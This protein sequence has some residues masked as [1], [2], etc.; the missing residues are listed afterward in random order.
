M[1]TGEVTDESI[2]KYGDL[3]FAN[4][5]EGKIRYESLEY[6]RGTKVEA[7]VDHVGI[8]VGDGK[9]LHAT[10]VKSEVVIESINDFKSLRKIIGVGRVSENL[11]EKRYIVNIPHERLDLKIKENIIEEV[12]RIIGYD[13]LVPTLPDLKSKKENN[14]EKKLEKKVGIINKE[15]YYQNAIR[16]VLFK[17][18]FSEVMNYSFVEKGELTLVKAA[19]T[20]KDRKSVV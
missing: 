15:L 9:I 17:N 18:S 8:Y 19:S 7:G 16:N 14:S 11:E 13:K 3:V 4:T 20:K 10:K 12:G 5:G 6:M 1:S 2:L